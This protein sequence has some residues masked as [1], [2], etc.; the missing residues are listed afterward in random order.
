MKV[1]WTVAD[2]YVNNGPHTTKIDDSDIMN[3]ETEHEVRNLVEEC[4]REDFEQKVEP[5]W[6]ESE[7]DAVVDFW[8][9]MKE[10]A[11]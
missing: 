6:R 8:K 7:V 10:H 4:I 5:D 2:G 3:C 11:S 1:E 9:E